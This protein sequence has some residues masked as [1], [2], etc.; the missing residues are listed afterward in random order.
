LEITI[1]NIIDN[2]KENI[3]PPPSKGESKNETFKGGGEE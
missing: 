3:P 2:D 1:E